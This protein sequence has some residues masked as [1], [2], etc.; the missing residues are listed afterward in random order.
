MTRLEALC[1][2][3]DAAARV[4]G[5]QGITVT[6]LMTTRSKAAVEGRRMLTAE[7]LP[8]MS[9]ELMADVLGFSATGVKEMLGPRRPP[10]QPKTKV[11]CV[12]WGNELVPAETYKKARRY[13]LEVRARGI[14]GADVRQVE[15]GEA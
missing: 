12:A 9:I 8:K 1:L 5:A 2:A 4:A 7:L 6:E 3:H 15:V 10:P 14:A 11:W 13:C